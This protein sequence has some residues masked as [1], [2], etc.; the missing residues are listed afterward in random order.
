MYGKHGMIV[1][2]TETRKL[3]STSDVVEVGKAT[4]GLDTICVDMKWTF[5]R[6]ISFSDLLCRKMC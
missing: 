2:K 3:T 4:G 6:L 1:W 5:C